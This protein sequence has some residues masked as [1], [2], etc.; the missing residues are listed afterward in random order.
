MDASKIRASQEASAASEKREG[1]SDGLVERRDGWAGE[2]T[3]RPMLVTLYCWYRQA[4]SCT[5]VGSLT[6]PSLFPGIYLV[7]EVE[8][9]VSV[10]GDGGGP[11]GE[12]SDH[13]DVAG[14]HVQHCHHVRVLRYGVGNG[15][16]AVSDNS[17]TRKKLKTKPMERRVSVGKIFGLGEELLCIRHIFVFSYGGWIRW[18]TL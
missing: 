5:T 17:R 10:V 11:V 13:T 14:E 8:D 7:E 15:L 6:R 2:R 1:H 12:H 4:L 9:A 16:E 18:P 3:F